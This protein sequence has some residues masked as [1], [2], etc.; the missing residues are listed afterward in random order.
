MFVFYFFKLC[1][2]NF[3]PFIFFGFH[4]SSFALFSLH[5]WSNDFLIFI[6]FLPMHLNLY[7]SKFPE[8]Q[9]PSVIF[10]I[11]HKFI[12]SSVISFLAQNLFGRILLNFQMYGN[13]LVIFLF[14]F[15]CLICSVVREHIQH[16]YNP[17]KFI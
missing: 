4:T 6:T 17:L 15:S 10:N 11:T 5:G 14:L 12:I 16:N 9:S 1:I 3:L 7:C 2:C 13:L 8:P